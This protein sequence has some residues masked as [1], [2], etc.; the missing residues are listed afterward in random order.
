MPT[1][2]PGKHYG[3]VL[4]R[5]KMETERNRLDVVHLMQA[6]KLEVSVRDRLDNAVNAMDETIRSINAFFETPLGKGWGED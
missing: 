6:N 5:I 1:D 3:A 4:R 2:N